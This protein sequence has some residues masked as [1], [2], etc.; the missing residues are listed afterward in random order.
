MQIR[1]R[2][3]LR[4]LALKGSMNTYQIWKSVP[5]EERG[6]YSAYQ[7]AVNSLLN[8]GLLAV[9]ETKPWHGKRT[10]NVYKLT[11]KGLFT[12]LEKEEMWRHI[13]QIATAN[14]ELAPEYFGLWPTF[15][16]LKIEE[17]AVKLLRYVVHRLRQGVPTFPEK[18]DDRK[19]TLRDWLPR[20]AI[21]PYDAM[22]EGVLTEREAFKFHTAII[23]D[24]EAEKFYLGVLNWIRESH[25]VASETWAK[26]IEKHNQLKEELQ[27]L[28]YIKKR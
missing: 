5:K 10:E 11:L 25:K 4:Q 7:K 2:Q 21:W 8:K 3:T 22:L 17:I 24:K 16:R 9:K 23:M 14:K 20:L 15:R 28:R 1:Q 26:A 12:T 13:H 27:K 19:P 18:I 6:E